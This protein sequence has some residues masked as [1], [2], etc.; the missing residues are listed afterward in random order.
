MILPNAEDA[1]VDLDELHK[2]CL[3][4]SH[5]IGRFKARV[6]ASVLDLSGENS[7]DLADALL[8][9]VKNH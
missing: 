5:P 6:F 7:Q 2:Y 8:Q 4:P 3:N 9:A 1:V